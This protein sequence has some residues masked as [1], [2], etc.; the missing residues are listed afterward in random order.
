MLFKHVSCEEMD[1]A[2]G[3]TNR[4]F[5]NNVQW[6]NFQVKGKNIIA[7]LKVRDSHGN[8][9]RMTQEQRHLISACWHVHGTFF[10]ALL[11]INPNAIIITQA[12][13]IFI[14]NGIIQNNW[15][16]RNI[17]SVCSPFSWSYA[18][19]CRKKEFQEKHPQYKM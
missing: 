7:T 5:N 10:E 13:T 8:G 6:N 19:E 2:L 16:D 4:K 12:Q 15:V 9:A 11:T 18:C 1:I 3:A 14:K 17:G